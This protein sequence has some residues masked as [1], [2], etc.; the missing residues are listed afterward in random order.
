LISF[1]KFNKA[2]F[3][4]HPLGHSQQHGIDFFGREN[5]KPIEPR[6]NQTTSSRLGQFLLGEDHSSLANSLNFCIF[7]DQSLQHWNLDGAV[8]CGQ[9]LKPATSPPAV[10]VLS[11]FA[12][13]SRVPTPMPGRGA[14]LAHVPGPPEVSSRSVL[15]LVASGFKLPPT[16]LGFWAVD[17]EASIQ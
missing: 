15:G 11:V 4:H 14:A 17:P 8:I 6:K 13:M 2:C 12:L 10:K 3:R 7:F 16:E 9:T 1:D 5:E